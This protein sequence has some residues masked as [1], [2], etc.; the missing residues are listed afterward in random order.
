MSI[1][2]VKIIVVYGRLLRDGGGISPPNIK[3]K[4][5]PK[6]GGW[7]CTTRRLYLSHHNIG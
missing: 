5:E 2:F 1:P 7:T 3:T 6:G 4:K